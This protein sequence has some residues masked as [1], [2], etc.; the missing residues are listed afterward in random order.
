MSTL[1]KAMIMHWL[2]VCTKGM[3][4][5]F[6]LN[7][8]AAGRARWQILAPRLTSNRTPSRA[9]LDHF[10]RLFSAKEYSRSWLVSV[11]TEPV[12]RAL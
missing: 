3:D 8:I 12:T 7:R 10:E 2:K 6:E 5:G 9:S 11:V 1:R 4:R